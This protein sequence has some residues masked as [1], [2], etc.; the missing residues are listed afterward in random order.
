MENEIRIRGRLLT[1]ADLEVIRQLLAAEGH[2]GRTHLSQ[3][4]CRV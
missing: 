1:A 3:R 2:R 4:L